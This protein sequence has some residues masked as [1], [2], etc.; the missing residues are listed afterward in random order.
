M[1]S[2]RFAVSVSRSTSIPL[3]EK[4]VGFIHGPVSLSDYIGRA[5]WN[6]AGQQAN[7]VRA[8]AGSSALV[9]SLGGGRA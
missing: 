6:C 3:G 9:L 4:L 2:D 7:R 5:E 1:R 8:P